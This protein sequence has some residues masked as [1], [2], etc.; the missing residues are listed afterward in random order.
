MAG[1]TDGVLLTAADATLKVAEAEAAKAEEHDARE[2]GGRSGKKCSDPGASETAQ[3]FP[4]REAQ[5]RSGN[6]RPS[7]QEWAEGGASFSLS[8]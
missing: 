8:P 6:Y 5:A 4:G 3:S 1:T 7:D 2:G